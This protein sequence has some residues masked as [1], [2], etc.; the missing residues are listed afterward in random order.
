M[1]EPTLRDY[2]PDSTDWK[3]MHALDVE[4]FAP[5]FRFTRRAMRRF[6]ETPAAITILAEAD[7]QLA[8]FGIAHLE[9]RQ[10]TPQRPATPTAYLVTL[11]IAPAF[12]RKG[13]ARRLMHELE[14]R[15]HAAGADHM[16]LHV[17]PGNAAALK[18]YE[19]L[20][21]RRAET[22]ADFYA[23]GLDALVYRKPLEPE[24]A[25]RWPLGPATSP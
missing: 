25:E 3:V 7:A 8:G 12:R 1:T 15:A 16:A 22:A 23:P 2:R 20:G 10:P 14:T 13:L 6:A 18:L 21:Y 19:A 11:D 24:P 9:N 17:F 5:P 4:C